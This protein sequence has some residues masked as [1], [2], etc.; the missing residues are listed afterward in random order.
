MVEIKPGLE[1]V[2]NIVVSFDRGEFFAVF[3]VK[4]IVGLSTFAKSVGEGWREEGQTESATN[5]D[6]E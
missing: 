5:S 1:L 2:V 6:D 4:I 3:Q